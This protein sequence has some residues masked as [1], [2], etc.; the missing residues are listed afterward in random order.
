MGQRTNYSVNGINYSVNVKK[1][2]GNEYY[3]VNFRNAQ[4][5]V[6]EKS[7]GM[8]PNRDTLRQAEKRAKEIVS[9]YAGQHTREEVQA[10]A[11]P[12][13]D[14]VLLGDF[15]ADWVERQKPLLKATTYDNYIS[16][17]N[18]HIIPYFNERKLK[19]TDVKPMH[20]QDY[21]NQKLT[22]VSS[23]TVRKHFSLIKTAMQDA[24]INDFIV[25][26]PAYKVKMPKK[27][28]PQHDFY[29]ADELKRLL[30]ASKGTELEVPIF[31]AAMFGLRRSE[32]IGLRWKDIDFNNKTLTINGSVTRHCI[33]GKWVDVYD[34]T[35]K[36][37]AS[38][39]TFALNDYVCGYFQNLYEH[40][41]NLI[42]NVDDYKEFV[43]VNEV[44]EI[45]KLDYIT[46]KFNKLLQQNELRHI[47]FHDIR[48]SA[49][50]LLS[51]YHSMKLVQ[52]YARH[53][54]FN[55][56]ADTYCHFNSN[57][58]LMELDTICTALNFG[59]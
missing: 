38:H 53:A 58:T 17:L 55:I 52:G 35:L 10:H 28:K 21:I 56:T 14:G 33:D 50:S 59:E 27:A 39:S 42:S 9:E 30:T 45:L 44:G 18:C 25:S 19:L 23:N 26:N 43:C 49:L 51:Q 40:N 47:R 4:G 57:D 48:H 8:K 6:V 41:M 32:V 24:V 36:T 31:L 16:M 46:H 54:N 20:L 5:K 29:T 15:I 22:R 3:V 2:K 7:T 1:V 37:D 11:V 12:D 13:E 34:D